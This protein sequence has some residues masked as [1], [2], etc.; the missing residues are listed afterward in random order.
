MS[1]YQ[2]GDKYPGD[3]LTRSPGMSFVD[4]QIW[5]QYFPVRF[6]RYRDLYYNVR[7]G[8]GADQA[9]ELT[10]V[11]ALNWWQITSRR[12][13]VVGVTASYNDIIEVRHGAT[14]NAIGRLLE[15]L[16]SW[17]QTPPLPGPVRLTLITN[18]HDGNL[19]DLAKPLGIRLIEIPKDKRAVLWTPAHVF[20][21]G[22]FPAKIAP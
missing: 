7:V 15:Y 18:T 8:T 21:K 9:K 6:D 11:E 20:N 2:T 14:P 19:A 10:P 17:W 12:I 22:D 4:D 16:R 5:R 13:D 3:A 1:N